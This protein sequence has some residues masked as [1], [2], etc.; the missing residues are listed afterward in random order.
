MTQKQITK[1]AKI[2]KMAIKNKHFSNFSRFSY[3]IRSNLVSLLLS[4]WYRRR[5]NCRRK[6]YC[7]YACGTRLTWR[8]PRA[9]F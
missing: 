6:K 2:T 5:M 4:V 9:A 3:F 7:S 8:G 1:T